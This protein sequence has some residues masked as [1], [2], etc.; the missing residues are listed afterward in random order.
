MKSID[1]QYK[2]QYKEIKKRYRKR[3]LIGSLIIGIIA[4]GLLSYFY[5]SIKDIIEYDPFF[6]TFS[7]IAGIGTAVIAIAMPFKQ[8][9]SEYIEIRDLNSA[10]T[11]ERFR[12]RNG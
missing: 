12:E 3:K 7:I 6:Q 8:T 11:H 1:E 5:L 4:I 2:A 9:H 10:Y